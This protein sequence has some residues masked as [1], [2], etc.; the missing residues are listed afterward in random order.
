[1]NVKEV[2]LKKALTLL[3]ATGAQYKVIMP[4][5]AEHG[6][7]VV[8]KGS[9]KKAGG[10]RRPIKYPMGS[11]IGYAR[12]YFEGMKVGDVVTIPAG[13][14]DIKI[15]RGSVA[16]TLSN[17]WGNGGHVSS[18]NGNGLEILRVK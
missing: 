6:T 18:L 12:P 4:D 5:G 11:V 1:M 7:L 15:I 9:V 17:L 3:A 2:A 13:E 10:K 14:F 8:K 16:S